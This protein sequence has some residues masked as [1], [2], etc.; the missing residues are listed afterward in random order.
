MTRAPR[1]RAGSPPPSRATGSTACSPS[2]PTSGVQAVV[3]IRQTGRAGSITAGTFD[4]G[5]EVLQAV[6][7]GRLSFAVDQQPYFQGYWPVTR[8]A[9]RAREGLGRG[10]REVIPTG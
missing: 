9:Q 5:P 1:P 3:A 6:R 2:T 8:L 7:R 10:A 4:L